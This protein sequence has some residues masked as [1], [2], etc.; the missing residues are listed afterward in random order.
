[1]ESRLKF[2]FEGNITFDGD[3]IKS[4]KQLSNVGILGFACLNQNCSLLGNK[5]SYWTVLNSSVA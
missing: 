3:L 4:N 5:I 2:I 1:M